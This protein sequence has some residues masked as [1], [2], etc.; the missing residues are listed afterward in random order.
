MKSTSI[1]FD[2]VAPGAFGCLH[3]CLGLLILGC[4]LSDTLS[5]AFYEPV[6]LVEFTSRMLNRNV[7]TIRTP[8]NDADRVRV[9]KKCRHC[10]SANLNHDIGSYRIRSRCIVFDGSHSDSI[11]PRKSLSASTASGSMHSFGQASWPL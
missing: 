6:D 1:I 2:S 9:R 5:T 10:I 4:C 3:P 7:R 11:L 8:L